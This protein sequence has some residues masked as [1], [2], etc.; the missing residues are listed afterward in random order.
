M[1]VPTVA[2]PPDEILVAGRWRRGSGTVSETIDPS[3]GSVIT[4]IHRA[5]V[6]DVDEA[7]Q[8]AAQ[9]AASPAWRDLLPHERA[10]YLHR[11]ADGIEGSA[12]QLARLQTRDTGKN[13][14]ETSALVASAAGTF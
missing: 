2:L 10:R 12:E 5:T 1:S 11:I 14:K 4:G 7:V 3:D 8:H 6:E 13:L 9:T